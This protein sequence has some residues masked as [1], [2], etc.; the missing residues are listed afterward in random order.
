[1]KQVSLTLVSERCQCGGRPLFLRCNSMFCIDRGCGI[2][3]VFME[4]LQKTRIQ[5]FVNEGFS[6]ESS[7]LFNSLW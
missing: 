2:I 5:I 1:M 4:V 3:Y 6:F 7:F